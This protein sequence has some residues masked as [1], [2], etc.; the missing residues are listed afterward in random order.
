MFTLQD[1]LNAGLPATSTDGNDANAATQFSRTLTPAEWLTYLSIADPKQ[2]KALQARIDAGNIPNWASWTQAQLQSWW[3][4]NLSDALVDGFAI[5]AGV[6]AML[7]AQ[8]AAL[9]RISQME[10]AIRDYIK[11]IE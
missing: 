1:L 11:L 6:K 2:A 7:K 4:A 8:N 9:L 10:I 3:D 5:P